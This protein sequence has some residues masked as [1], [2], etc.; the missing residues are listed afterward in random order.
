LSETTPA[1]D[2]ADLASSLDLTGRKLGDYQLLR[3]LGRGGMAEVYLAEQLSLR[4]QVALKVLLKSLAADETYVRRFQV[5]AQAAAS[6]V[7]ANVVQIHEVGCVDGIHFIAQ[8]YVQGQNLRQLL[9]KS[10]PPDVRRAIVIMRQVA[11]ALHQAAQRGIIHRDIKPENI[12]LSR[13]GEVKVADFGLA[14]VMHQHENLH[15]TQKDVTMGT[16]LYMSP[17]QVE[18]KPLDPRSDLYSL[19]VTCYHMLSGTPP[20]RAETAL[21]VAVQ[22][23]KTD[24]VR[25]ETLRPDLPPAL[26][27]IVHKLLA[28]DPAQR[29]A[30][31]LDLMRDL[32]TVRVPGM[33]DDFEVQEGDPLLEL[34]LEIAGR[35]EATQALD[36]LMKTQ[37]LSLR[38]RRW[39]WMWPVV[40]GA[41]AL[42]LGA[43]LAWS[44]REPSLLAGADATRTNIPRQA[45]PEAQ[46]LYAELTSDPGRAELAYR[47]VR[48]YFPQA[49]F[50]VRAADQELAMIYLRRDD[51]KSALKLF[52]SFAD[53]DDVDSEYK[54]FGLA[55]QSV[56][57]SLQGRHQ[58]SVETLSEL[59]PLR[60]RL[61]GQ[62][63]MQELLRQVIPRSRQAM[64]READKQWDAWLNERFND[65]G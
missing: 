64:N 11:A 20:F 35:L 9:T 37:A 5:E 33:D 47:A 13:S 8:E 45:T 21:G 57:Y 59:S 24:A 23:L 38:R 1:T 6:F 53:A 58:E 27:R 32:R 61:A 39:S 36:G 2:V 52:E 41:A 42:A 26:P 55:G 12:L 25:L 60:D 56:V 40:G 17:E 62:P 48:E 43:L 30:S 4:R 54:A 28:K 7:H 3:R 63:Q 14:R 65:G 50:Q 15:L 19:G 29:Y 46:F 22:H 31:A 16:P 34:P 44:S 49:V 10:G 18:G 51:L